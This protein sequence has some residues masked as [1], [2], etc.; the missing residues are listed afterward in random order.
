MLYSGIYSKEVI[1]ILWAFWML[2]GSL[3]LFH[4]ILSPSLSILLTVLVLFYEIVTRETSSLLLLFCA[5]LTSFCSSES[6]LS[7]SGS[8]ER[9]CIICFNMVVLSYPATP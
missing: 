5:N 7:S 1:V 3:C 9:A 2:D 6:N 4:H 8:T